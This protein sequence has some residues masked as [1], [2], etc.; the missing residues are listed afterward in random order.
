MN[1]LTK[2]NV[3]LFASANSWIE[4]EALRQLYA[5]SKLEG[6]RLTVGFPDLHPGKGSPVGAASVTEGQIYPYLIGGDI[7][8]GMTLFKTDLVQREIKL[9]R[10]TE[11]RF[12]LEHQWEGDVSEVLAAAEL[13]STEFEEALGTIG[14][15]NHFAELQR[16]EE[17]LDATA[18]KR[19]GLGKQQ[20]VVLVHS[21]SRG[22][23][24][25][26]LRAYVDEHQA[27]GSDAESFAAAA[28]LKRHDM[29]VRWAKANR[30]LIARRFVDAIGAQ[31]ECLWDG[32]HNSIT[33]RESEGETL[34]VH[35][36]GAVETEGEAVVIPGSRGSLS[37]LVK[38]LGDGESRA[39]SLA[40]GAGRKWARSEARLRMRER[41]GKEQLVQ[42]SLGSRVICGER[43][44]LYE[45]APA[46][47]KNIEAVIQ[48][49][50]DTGLVSVIAT[51]CPLLTYKTRA[52]D[53][54]G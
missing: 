39:W 1:T 46:A 38:P 23:G 11:L 6:M 5:T 53:Y 52:K 22:L 31:A 9:N 15:G 10:W 30:A 13:D 8:C 26:I 20:L 41:Y 37:Y 51:F 17:I 12:D 14:G 3:R 24:E 29:A 33:R 32:C 4:G 50:V 36:K 54:T 43:D 47:Y 18:F 42:T 35:R 27:N 40:H 49:L 19:F 25:S 7:G 48:D 21:G 44:L 28:Y 45:E 16:L 34:W 2:T